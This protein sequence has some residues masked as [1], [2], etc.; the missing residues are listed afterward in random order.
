MAPHRLPRCRLVADGAIPI[1]DPYPV[2]RVE[3]NGDRREAQIG[4]RRMEARTTEALL[5]RVDAAWQP[6]RRGVAA[7]G[8]D[9][10]V[11]RT[12]A[13]WSVKEMLAHVAF[14]EETVLNLLPPLLGRQA[15]DLA[16]WYGGE[17][18]DLSGDWAHYDVHNER[19]ATWANG[20]TIERVLSRL[21]TSHA[22]LTSLLATLTDEQVASQDI[23]EKVACET[24]EHYADHMAELEQRSAPV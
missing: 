1:I 9:Q 7:L 13:G 2:P 16:D 11:L 10:L 14:W 18:L 15:P 12:D 23:W 3:L 17:G 8:P 5:A 22:R 24:F 19:E 6:F 21:D 4:M 20:H